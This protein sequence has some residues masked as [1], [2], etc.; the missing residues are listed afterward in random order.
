MRKSEPYRLFK[1][2]LLS[3]KLKSNATKRKTRKTRLWTSLMA[4]FM[5]KLSQMVKLA[6]FVDIVGKKAGRKRRLFLNGITTVM[7]SM[8]HANARY[9][10]DIAV[11]KMYMSH[12]NRLRRLLI[13]TNCHS[14]TKPLRH[15][16]AGVS[17]IPSSS[18]TCKPSVCSARTPAPAPTHSSVRSLGWG[19]A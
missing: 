17:L 11:A 3:S 16:R 1:A 13:Q 6:Q 19:S 7:D 18:N 4:A 2:R 5:S 12:H 15:R 14:N 8:K 9:A 10:K